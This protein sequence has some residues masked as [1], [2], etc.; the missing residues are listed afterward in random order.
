MNEML[1]EKATNAIMLAKINQKMKKAKK[2]FN[3][4]DYFELEIRWMFKKFIMDELGDDYRV[5]N[6]DDGDGYIERLIYAG[7][8][9]FYFYVGKRAGYEQVK[10]DFNRH[11]IPQ[12]TFAEICVKNLQIV[13]V[14]DENI[15]ERDMIKDEFS[16]MLD[17]FLYEG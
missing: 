6:F 4:I 17:K 5:I 16:K 12:E 2:L 13:L 15:S 1:F 9:Y 14:F 7:H 8:L 10:D 11:R 3:K